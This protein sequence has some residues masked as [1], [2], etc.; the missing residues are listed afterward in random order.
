MRKIRRVLGRRRSRKEGPCPHCVFAAGNL[1]AVIPAADTGLNEW[2]RLHD[3]I[4]ALAL[5]HIPSFTYPLEGGGEVT[6]SKR[7]N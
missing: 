6:F 3:A 1:R 5:G 4:D 2:V 7:R